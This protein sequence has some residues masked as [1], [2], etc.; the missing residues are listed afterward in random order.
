MT[1]TVACGFQ[2]TGQGKLEGGHLFLLMPLGAVG[3]CLAGLLGHGG[4]IAARGSSPISSLGGEEEYLRGCP[5]LPAG[6]NRLSGV[7]GW[8]IISAFQ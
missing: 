5:A 1:L 8:G 3:S 4:C 2:T 6:L 7:T